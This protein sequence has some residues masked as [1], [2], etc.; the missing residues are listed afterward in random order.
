MEIPDTDNRTQHAFLHNIYGLDNRA[1][2]TTLRPVGIPYTGDLEIPAILLPLRIHQ[3]QKIA[4]VLQLNEGIYIVSS[5]QA[6]V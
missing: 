5:I 6:S 1:T 3:S 4:Q 2:K